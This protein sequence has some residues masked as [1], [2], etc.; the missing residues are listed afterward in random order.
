MP[1]LTVGPLRNE[2][3]RRPFQTSYRADDNADLKTMT[4]S[5]VFEMDGAK[6]YVRIAA[7]VLATLPLLAAVVLT[8]RSL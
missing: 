7:F 3:G 4:P 1:G 6:T 8:L 2:E 5:P